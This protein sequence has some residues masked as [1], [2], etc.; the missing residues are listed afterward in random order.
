MRS[1]S[2]ARGHGWRA[3]TALLA[4][5]LAM[6]GTPARAAE[7]LRGSTPGGAAY[8]IAVPDG[9]DAGDPLV[10]VNHGLNLELDADPDLGPLAAQ[11]LAAGYAIAA[12]GFRQRSWALFRALDDNAE[13]LQVFRE[14]F[15]EPGSIIPMGGSMGGLIALKQAEDPRFPNVTGV[16]ALCPA[17]AGAQTWDKALDVRLS[18]D[19]ICDGVTGGELPRGDQPTPW[20]YDLDDIPGNLDDPL[21]DPDV[22]EALARVTVC[23]GL[24]LPPNLRSAAQEGRLTRL[25]AVSGVLSEQFLTPVLAYA[26][27]GL[28]DLVRADDKLGGGNPFDTRGVVYGDSEINAEVPRFA[29]DPFAQFELVKRSTLTGRTSARI[30]AMH[31]SGDQLLPIEHLQEILTEST[32]YH[33]QRVP[34]DQAQLLRVDEDAPTHCGFTQAE[35]LAGWEA[36]RGWIASGSKPPATAVQSSCRALVA[37]GVAE[38]ACRIAQYPCC[39]PSIDT[40]IAPRPAYDAAEYSKRIAGLWYTPERDG[41]GLYVEP[42]ANGRVLVTWYT[43]PREGEA[44]DQLWLYGEGRLSGNGFETDALLRLDGGRFAGNF[45]PDDVTRTAWGKLTFVHDGSD[46]AALRFEGPEGY[47]SGTRA[48]V[49]LTRQYPQTVLSPPPPPVF[50]HGGSFYDPAHPGE[51]VFVH[52][53]TDSS[54]PPRL[55]SLYLLWF[56]FDGAGRPRWYFGNYVPI[57]LDPPPPG[58]L[59]TFDLLRPTGTRFGNAFHA[60]DIQRLRVGFVTVVFDQG[61]LCTPVRLEYTVRDPNEVRGTLAFTRLSSPATGG[62]VAAP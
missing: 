21:S 38:G 57:E 31:T 36:L 8:V 19:V 54:D 29:P 4:L 50:G 3:S 18:Y 25:K 59:Y 44:G 55:R 22:V 49:R 5:A 61:D 1:R 46:R 24:A 14:R 26:T 47:G 48:L 28:G 51:G 45:D 39:V 2:T 27:F 6:T 40:R 53:A 30:L 32:G 60:G 17:A 43:Y 33:G 62:C 23:T 52:V 37:G 9:W 10:F 20:A 58:Y 16:Y 56:T 34:F 42:I 15:G 7:E 13:L 41:E 11:Q 12:S 35:A